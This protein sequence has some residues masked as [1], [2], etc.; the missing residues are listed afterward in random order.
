MA[1]TSLQFMYDQFEAEKWRFFGIYDERGEVVYK[2]MANLEPEKAYNKLREWFKQNFGTFTV[3][4]FMKAN[5]MAAAMEQNT[6]ARFT[7]EVT[8]QNQPV[9][10]GTI[11]GQQQQQGPPVYAA[12]PSNNVFDGAPN[13][14][15]LVDQNHG[16][17]TELQLMK[18]DHD[19]Q[20]EMDQMRRELDALKA[21]QSKSRGFGA[22]LEHLGK[23]FNDPAVIMGAVSVVNRLFNK[24]SAPQGPYHP[25][26]HITPMNGIPGGIA[27]T[28]TTGRV[29]FEVS[30]NADKRR[31]KLVSAVNQLM[32]SDPDFPENMAKLAA[33]SRS[34][35]AVYK[36]AISYLNT[37]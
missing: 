12:Q 23:Q 8:G 26:Q 3:K 21:E 11:Y 28:T 17:R 24:P 30:R 35:P 7:V 13:Q 33:L 22:I 29:D 16:F 5:S 6:L 34:N 31:D 19:H 32:E 18:K 20:R 9:G 15:N 37:L 14:W 25:A 27:P 1:I 10:M 4:V 36:M 2:Q